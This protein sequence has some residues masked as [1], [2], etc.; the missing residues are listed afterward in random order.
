M[1]PRNFARAFKREVGLTPAAYVE[2]VRLEGAQHALETTD[3][4]VEVVCRRCGFGTP[5]TMRRAFRRRVGVS[6]AE[7][8]A[9]FRPALDR[10][11]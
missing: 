9:R 8:R 5:E 7:Y 6:P 1:S 3:S 11:A 2:R 4:P 10:A